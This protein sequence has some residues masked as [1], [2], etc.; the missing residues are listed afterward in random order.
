MSGSNAAAAKWK[1]VTPDNSPIKLLS[2]PGEITWRHVDG[3]FNENYAFKRSAAYSRQSASNTKNSTFIFV[4]ELMPNFYWDSGRSKDI[5]KLSFFNSSKGY[6]K[7]FYG[8]V[9][10]EGQKF[11][12]YKDHSCGFRNIRFRVNGENCQYVYYNPDLGTTDEWTGRSEAPFSTE[13]IH[14]GTSTPFAENSFKLDGEKET[15]TITYPGSTDNTETGNSQVSR[16]HLPFKR[17][18][19]IRWEGEKKLIAGTVELSKTSGAG[20]IRITLPENAGSCRGAFKFDS[21]RKGHWSVSC[22]NGLS[23]SG[24]MTGYGKGKGSSGVG[25]DAD[26]RSVTFTMGGAS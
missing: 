22:T 12:C 9:F 1:S 4:M 17:P 3:G 5:R 26:G 23:A 8:A 10:E 15:V 18:I 2:W 24:T 16:P 7:R 11:S 25:Y 6:F 20:K 19:A 14:C 21:S 13:I